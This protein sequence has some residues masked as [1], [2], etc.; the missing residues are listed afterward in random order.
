M[1]DMHTYVVEWRWTYLAREGTKEDLRGE[2]HDS[3][4][5]RQALHRLALTLGINRLSQDY[6]LVNAKGESTGLMS[7]SGASK[8]D[9]CLTF[10]QEREGYDGEELLL[11]CQ[12]QIIVDMSQ[13]SVTAR[14]WVEPWSAR[15]IRM[16]FENDF[17]TLG[18]LGTFQQILQPGRCFQLKVPNIAEFHSKRMNMFSIMAVVRSSRIALRVLQLPDI[19]PASA[20]WDQPGGADSINID[21]PTY[22]ISLG[23]DNSLDIEIHV[24]DDKG[25]SIKSYPASEYYRDHHSYEETIKLAREKKVSIRHL[26]T[27]KGERHAIFLERFMLTLFEKG[28]DGKYDPHIDKYRS[29]EYNPFI[30]QMINPGHQRKLFFNKMSAEWMS[31]GEFTTVAYRCFLEYALFKWCDAISVNAELFNKLRFAS[32]IVSELSKHIPGVREA[33]GVANAMDTHVYL[34][35]WYVARLQNNSSFLMVL[36]PNVPLTSRNRHFQPSN[37]QA[38]SSLEARPSS[39]SSSTQHRRKDSEPTRQ[40]VHTAELERTMQGGAPNAAALINN[41]ATN[42]YTLLM[43]CSMDNGEMHRHVRAMDIHNKSVTKAKLNLWPLDVPDQGTRVLG[44]TLQGFVGDSEDDQDAPIPFTDHALAQIKEIERM[45]SE[46]YLQTIYLALLL[47]RDVAPA[48]ILACQ[49]STL[50]KRRSI[51]VDI[52]AFLHSQDVAR[53]S[54]DAQWEEQDRK[55]L[56]AKFVELLSES[57][58]SLPFDTNPSQGRYYF[59]KATPDKRSELEVCLQLAENP[60]FISF[61]CSIE[62]YDGDIGHKRRLNMPVDEL[63]LSLEQLCEQAGI[64][65]RPPIDHFVPLTSVRVIL[66]IGC[67]Y[68]PD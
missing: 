63:P 22:E 23:R 61:Q 44:E 67:L 35:K 21:D 1:G 8:Y 3:E 19:S 34:E 57:F 50:W 16:L 36:L 54:R 39:S 27:T 31:T 18:P 62:V 38:D 9:S 33:T 17:S 68:L 20:V 42:T 46:S 43:E 14:T 15:V 7:G 52:T 66:H 37:E 29:N 59:C 47:N 6:T 45:Y 26:G 5:V 28:P 4:I 49:Q 60:L 13:S 41:A 65:W 51:D 25:N 53:I 58:N 30:L 48:D 55:G 40:T 12:Y 56:Q 10:Y 64:P 24:L 11:A 32:T 2:G